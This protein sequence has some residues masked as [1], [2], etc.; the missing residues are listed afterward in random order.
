MFNRII[1]RTAPRLQREECARADPA[2]RVRGRR[3]VEFRIQDCAIARTPLHYALQHPTH[4][5]A[6]RRK[7][8]TA[9]PT[10][11]S[12]TELAGVPSFFALNV[13]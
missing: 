12:A 5:R 10:K 2:R 8:M 4:S 6:S 3:A 1:S 11:T 13:D 9:T 7:T